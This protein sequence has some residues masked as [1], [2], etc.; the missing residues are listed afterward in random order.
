MVAIPAKLFPSAPSRTPNEADP[1]AGVH[2]RPE[3][4][5]PANRAVPAHVRSE[6]GD[7]PSAQPAKPSLDVIIDE[8]GQFVVSDVLGAV[9]GVGG[10]AQIAFADYRAAARERLSVL[11]QHRDALAP[12]LARQLEQLERLLSNL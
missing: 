3:R 6:P 8:D 1:R 10:T 9:Y 4:L 2:W 11:R 5:A 7:Q 12:R